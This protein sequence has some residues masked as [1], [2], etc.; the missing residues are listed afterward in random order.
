MKTTEQKI[1]IA[2]RVRAS[3]VREINQL[4]ERYGCGVRPGWVSEA[5][6]HAGIMRDRRDDEIADLERSLNQ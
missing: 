2:R 1:Q 5:I 3:Y 4:R 6:A